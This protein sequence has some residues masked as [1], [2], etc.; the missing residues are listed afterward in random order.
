[1]N[2]RVWR[3]AALAMT[4]GSALLLGGCGS[5]EN[6]GTVNFERI[7][8]ESGQAQQI[9]QE[10]V[11]KQQEIAARL[12]AA[13][14][15]GL[16]AE[17]FAK[18]EEEARREMRIFQLSKRQQFEALVQNQAAQIAK[19]KNLGIIMHEQAVHYKGVD[20]TDDLLKRLQSAGG[21]AKSDNAT[22]KTESQGK[23]DGQAKS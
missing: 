4:L 17:E 13:S 1:M 10:M 23:S 5:Q 8:K 20:V 7:A 14:Q 18:K 6:V 11:A 16:S 9:T 19:E 22:A 21:A 12:E 3:Q 2:N 15:Q